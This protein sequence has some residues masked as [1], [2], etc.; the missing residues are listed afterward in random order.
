M[1]RANVSVL[2]P[3]IPVVGLS[4]GFVLQGLFPLSLGAPTVTAVLGGAVLCVSVALVLA[5]SWELTRAQTAFDVRR[6]TTRLVRSGVFS[7]SRNPVY[8]AMVLLCWAIGLLAD[9]PWV[10][11]LAVPT[12]SLLC[13]IVIR[14]EERYL[15]RKFGDAYRAYCGDV[16][17]WI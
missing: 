7:W 6:T 11:L 8:L 3:V 5:A 9:I 10:L 17:R 16:R 13:L 4:L 2:P 1:D 14:R 15:G 12:A